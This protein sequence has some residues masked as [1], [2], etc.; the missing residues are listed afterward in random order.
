VG[1]DGLSDGRHAR[2]RPS[3]LT[4]LTPPPDRDTLMTSLPSKDAAD[5]L[6][7]RFFDSYNPA[8]PAK[9]KKNSSLFLN[10][11]KLTRTSGAIHIPTFYKQVTT[12]SH[13]FLSVMQTTQNLTRVVSEA[14]GG[15]LKDQDN[16]GWIIILGIGVGDAHL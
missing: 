1:S 4:G 16:L 6:L 11:H 8:L 3:F 5:K 10:I 12:N 13:I 15:S 7:N 2:Y 9:C 14:L